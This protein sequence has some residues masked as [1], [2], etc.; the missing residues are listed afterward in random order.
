MTREILDELRD[1]E[2]RLNR[3]RRKASMIARA[4]EDRDDYPF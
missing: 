2:V 1:I 3:I 4:I